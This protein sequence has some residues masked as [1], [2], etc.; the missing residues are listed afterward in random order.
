MLVLGVFAYLRLNTGPATSVSQGSVSAQP[1]VENKPISVS[2]AGTKEGVQAAF[3]TIIPLY[4]TD[5]V[6]LGATVM[7]DNY[8]LQVW[9]SGNMG[10]QALLKYNL[11]QGLW[12]FITANGGAW[13]EAGLVSAGVPSDTA[14]TLLR[15]L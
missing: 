13:S 2:A 6:T 14:Q 15:G 11:E 5:P 8:A 7:A 3:R 12:I 10:G 1:Q 4:I 9:K